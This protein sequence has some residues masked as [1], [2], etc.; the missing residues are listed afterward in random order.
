MNPATAGP[1]RGTLS[2]RARPRPGPLTRS[3]MKPRSLLLGTS[4]FIVG[5]AAGQLTGPHGAP[6]PDLTAEAGLMRLDD[7]GGTNRRLAPFRVVVD[8]VP[9]DLP[10]VSRDGK[11]W[12]LDLADGRVTV[13]A[14]E[15]GRGEP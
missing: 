13:F 3:P 14:T 5:L 12:R 10:D 1:K 6:A 9:T 4:L 8:G 7:P 11:R 2:Q 15:L